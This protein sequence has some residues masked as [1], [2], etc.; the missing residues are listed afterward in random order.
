VNQFL[1]KIGASFEEPFSNRLEEGG[2]F[3]IAQ[4]LVCKFHRVCPCLHGMCE[5]GHSYARVYFWMVMRGTVNN[6]GRSWKGGPH[7]LTVDG[8]RPQ[9][10]GSV[11][12]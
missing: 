11:F 7:V 5:V 2:D 4:R 12:I 1:R 3:R 9:V 6:W 10:D 8:E